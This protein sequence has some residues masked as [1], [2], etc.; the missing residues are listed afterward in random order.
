[1]LISNEKLIDL[2]VHTLSGQHLGKIHS[3]TIEADSQFI[4]KYFV[5]PSGVVNIFSKDLTIDKEQVID[6]T[7][8]KM[9]VDDSVYTFLSKEEIKKQTKKKLSPGIAISTDSQ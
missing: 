9:I 2:P 6:I 1:M 8:D 7:K 5:K 3:F 4:K